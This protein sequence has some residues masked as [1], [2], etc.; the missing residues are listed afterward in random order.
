MGKG[1]CQI[2]EERTPKPLF[3]IAN[4]GKNQ[5]HSIKKEDSIEA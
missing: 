2:A 5:I 4:N 3:Y 1:L